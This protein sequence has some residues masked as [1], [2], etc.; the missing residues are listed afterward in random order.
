MLHNSQS[1]VIP[2]WVGD[3]PEGVIVVCVL[4]EVDEV[5]VALVVGSDQLSQSTQ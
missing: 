1:D 4:V 3:G 2:A 5:E